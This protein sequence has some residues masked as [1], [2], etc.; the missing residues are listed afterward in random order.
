M[1]A[2]RGKDGIFRT[3]E[4][5]ERT[6]HRNVEEISK[7]SSPVARA[8][9]GLDFVTI[10]GVQLMEWKFLVF[11]LFYSMVNFLNIHLYV[12]REDI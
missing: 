11:W 12:R 3:R 9:L 8:S 6:D 5:Y 10:S 7:Y 1:F 4:G 2:R